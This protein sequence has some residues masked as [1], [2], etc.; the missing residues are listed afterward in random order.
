MIKRIFKNMLLAQIASSASV[1]ICMLVDSI[2]IGQFLG[3]DAVA[4]YGIASPVLFIFAAFGALMSTGIQVVCSKSLT[5]GDSKATNDCYT[6]SIVLA[7]AVSVTGLIAVYAATNP[8]CSLLGAK[9]GT[10]VFDLTKNYLRGFM[11][12]APGFI[13]AQILVPFMLLSNNRS[14]LVVAVSVMTVSDI[15][16]DFLNVLLFN[17]GMFG[18]GVA[19]ALSYY[20]AL[21]IAA[22]YLLS[23]RCIYK[24][25]FRSFRFRNIAVVLKNGIP[26]AVNQICYT[27][28]VFAINQILLSG[29]HSDGVAVY[30]VLSTVG[31]LCFAIGSGIGTVSLA[32]AGVFYSEED[33]NSLHSLVSIFVKYAFWLDLIAMI[34]FMVFAGP[35]MGMFIADKKRAL[36]LGTI[37]LRIFLLC[38]IPSSINSSFKNYYLGIERTGLS[39][40]ISFL[41]NLF[42]PVLAALILNGVF[43][44]R[45]VWFAFLA[46]EMLTLV[47]ICAVSWTKYGRMAFTAPAF[48][49]LDADFGISDDDIIDI[50]LTSMEQVTN[51]AEEASNF[52]VAHEGDVKTRARLSLCIEEM[53][54]N[55]IKHGFS[56]GKEHNM[57]L[58]VIYKKGSWLICFRDD[59]KSF[60]PVKYRKKHTFDNSYSRMGLRLVFETAKDIRYVNALGLNNLTISI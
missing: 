58:R 40:V 49:L 36:A 18:M 6:V 53:G 48:S 15:L 10:V 46:G 4:A 37:A 8:I 5:K 35:I 23:K 2:M 56:D 30:S 32:L 50:P 34:V 60:D 12:G 47:V 25:D 21:M 3:V 43:G 41:Q 33:K 14:R 59:C 22:V 27:L 42:F 45:G 57:Q 7:L 44:M 51:A 52:C 28:E 31:S 17:G 20:F 54:T 29:G 13:L 19:S 1:T 9:E 26:T 11:F 38:L 39:E 16:M 55:I 24:F